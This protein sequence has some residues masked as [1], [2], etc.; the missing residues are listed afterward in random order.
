V[1]DAERR[2]ILH[3]LAAAECEVTHPV[4]LSI[5]QAEMEELVSAGLIVR[6]EDTGAYQLTEQGQREA[7]QADAGMTTTQH[8][9]A[10]QEAIRRAGG[11]ENVRFAGVSTE[12]V[13]QARIGP[14]NIEIVQRDDGLV[15][16]HLIEY[17]A[18]DGG[19]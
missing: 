11:P 12:L 17:E 4:G 2:T 8:T 6:L 9:T 10:V 1:T 7:W 19:T 15:E 5:T 14:V 16:L 18:E 13:K 3:R